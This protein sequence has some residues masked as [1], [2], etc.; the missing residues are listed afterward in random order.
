[1]QYYQNNLWRFKTDYASYVF[2]RHILNDLVNCFPLGVDE[3]I[4]L[5]NSYWSNIEAFVEGDMVYHLLDLEWASYVYWKPDWELKEN[6]PMRENQLSSY[7]LYE[8]IRP[9]ES[10]YVDDYIFIDSKLVN[11]YLQK[12]IITENYIKTFETTANN[13]ELALRELSRHKGEE[14]IKDRIFEGYY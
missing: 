8:P 6:R 9:F 2:M 13:Y 1:M 7:E 10:D 14:Y 12:G 4:K 11:D 5:I 3:A